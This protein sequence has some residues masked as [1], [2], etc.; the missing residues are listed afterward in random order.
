[1]VQVLGAFHFSSSSTSHAAGQ[2]AT[3]I[4]CLKRAHFHYHWAFQTM[5]CTS[6]RLFSILPICLLHFHCTTPICCWWCCSVVLVGTRSGCKY[7]CWHM[8]AYRFCVFAWTSAA[9]GK[10][11]SHIMVISCVPRATTDRH[12]NC[13]GAHSSVPLLIRDAENEILNQLLRQIEPQR[14]LVSSFASLHIHCKIFRVPRYATAMNVLNF[15]EN[16]RHKVA[17]QQGHTGRV[18]QEG[19]HSIFA[20]WIEALVS[21]DF[22]GGGKQEDEEVGLSDSVLH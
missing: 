2:A 18:C 3:H 17:W 1:M 20:L 14:H 11:P 7:E 5:C 21:C 9:A 22:G 13:I 19:A 10:L 8:W 4:S 6:A 15:R 16:C 12:C